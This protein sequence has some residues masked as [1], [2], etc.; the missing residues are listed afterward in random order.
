M[1]KI[2]K[3]KVFE[4]LRERKLSVEALAE[5][6]GK[7]KSAMYTALRS[8]Q[9]HYSTIADIADVLQVPASDIIIKEF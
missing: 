8:S 1:M 6:I 2:D 7:S 9:S 4:L 5:K 3:I